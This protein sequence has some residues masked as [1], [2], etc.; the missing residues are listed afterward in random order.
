M[1][2]L[3]IIGMTKTGGKVP[4]ANHLRVLHGAA[5]DRD[6]TVEYW[7][8]HDFPGETRYAYALTPIQDDSSAVDLSIVI[9][10]LNEEES[11]IL[12]H[13]HITQ[14]LAKLKSSYEVIYVDDGST[15][16]T[17]KLL[18]QI[19][20]ADDR[21]RVIRLRRNFG[22]TAAFSAGFDFARGEVIITMDGDLQNDA[23]DIPSLLE[24]IDEGYDVVSGWRKNRQDVFLTRRLP[25]QIANGLISRVTGVR[26]HDYGCSL[27]AYRRE[28][29]KNIN[30]YGDMH[31][32][33]PA[34]ASWMGI[35]VAEIPVN[36][37]A[38]KY[39]R[40]KYGLGRTTKVVLDLLTVKF[41][42][43]YA[44]RPIQ[45]F[46]LMGLISLVIGIGTGMYLAF[47][48]LVMGQAIGDRPLLLLAVLL[49]VI[50][51]NLIIMGL[52][53]ELVVRTYHEAQGKPIYRIREVIEAQP[54]RDPLEQQ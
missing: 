48:R 42:L 17:Y 27:K 33:I 16:G 24:K 3:R 45:I 20:D 12:L 37:S 28:V 1:V 7:G 38:R 2:I 50:G 9:P 21:V 51:V 6:W 25:S 22:Q 19:A 23:G 26:L 10:L 46:G 47:L 5:Q 54:R 14:A 40:S 15:D 31:R 8:P 30:L 52:L 4:N 18:Q 44:T 35:Q 36:H 29:V 39:G 13:D 41:L 32:F 11:V 53:G 43:D 34:L 49:V